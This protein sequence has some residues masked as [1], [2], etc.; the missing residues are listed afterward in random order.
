MLGPLRRVQGLPYGRKS[1][2]GLD[3]S[4]GCSTGFHD[5]TILILNDLRS[6]ERGG[7]SETSPTLPV[8]VG[9]VS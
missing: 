8:G 2:S 7:E 1:G 6:P 4:T 9:D 3:R 5:S